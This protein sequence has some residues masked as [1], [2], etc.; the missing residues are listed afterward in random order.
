MSYPTPMDVAESE[1]READLS[2]SEQLRNICT[3]LA[4]DL[5]NSP[6]TREEWVKLDADRLELIAANYAF[7]SENERLTEEHE[8]RRKEV[9][10]AY[11]MAIR[12]QEKIEQL[13]GLLRELDESGAVANWMRVSDDLRERVRAALAG[14]KP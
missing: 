8:K 4:E 7:A 12:K 11:S 6:F 3:A 13:R 5:D 14:E 9:S 1:D 10:A 2:P